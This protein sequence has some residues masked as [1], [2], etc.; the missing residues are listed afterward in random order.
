MIHYS[1]DIDQIVTLTLDMKNRT[2]NVINHEISKSFVPV[3]KQ[4]REEKEK[5]KLKGVIITSAKKTFLAGGDL[6][7]LYNATTAADVYHFSQALKQFFREIES[8][9]V[10]VVAAINGSALGTGFEMAMACHHRIVVDEPTVRLG[11]PEVSLGLMPGSG[12]VIR[13]MWL[14]GIKKAFDVLTS[15]KSY[16]PKEALEVG[17]ID[18]LAI[19]K[20]DMM[21]KARAYL[22]STPEA[23]RPWD[24]EGDAIPGGTAHNDRIA[25]EISVMSAGLANG[26][27]NNFPAYLA[28]L[29]TLV[30]G[31]KVDFDTA[32]RIESRYFT[33]LLLSK[34]SKNMIK[35]FWYDFNAIKEGANRP[36]GFGRFRPRRIGIIGAGHMGS[37]IAFNCVMNGMEVV[38]KDVSKGIADRGKNFS[39][40]KLTDC[41]LKGEISEK[42][43]KQFLNNI[44]TTESFEDF[45]TCDLVIECV[46]ENEMVKSKVTKESEMHMDEYA[47]FASNTISIPITQLAESSSRPEN[48]VG[49]H[50]FAPVEEVPLVEIVK[51][52][53]TSDETIARAFDFVKKIRKTPI[54]VKDSWGFFAS[55]VQNTYILE[56]LTMLE[57]GYPPALI[58]NLGVQTG[59]PKGALALADE[60]SLKLALKYENQAAVNYGPKYIQ[61]PAVHV[62]E[63]MVNELSRSGKSAKS[64]FYNYSNP[65]QPILWNGLEEHFP[66]RI[67]NYSENHIID[68]FLFAQAIEAV[69]CLQEKVIQSVPEANLGSI[70]GFGFPAF[71]GG[72]IQ[73]INDYGIKDF[74]VKCEELEKVHGPRFKAPS[75][76]KKKAE[77][78]EMF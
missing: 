21:E 23:K 15:G 52:R 55:R 8:P 59:M 31:S 54:I 13:M 45:K 20:K 58:E 33:N 11:H 26:Y 12:S 71:K 32:C 39:E 64:G 60:L 40:K 78:E 14:L 5:G 77:K 66:N 67:N 70:Y 22:L 34:E 75:L 68:R 53:K 56:G 69:W 37:G 49:L 16:M 4:L 41:T 50:F 62:L 43:K 47:F 10:P 17:I 35:A 44:T 51:G 25:R 73:Y 27:K 74:V 2:V 9:G 42:E 6:D 72:V 63:K 48:Y 57:E 3:L 61:H 24:M 38:L 65:D 19:N 1:K 46:F 7:Y 36:K 29:S 18:E 28:I 76:L 30:E